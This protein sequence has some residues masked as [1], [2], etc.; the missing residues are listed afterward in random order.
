MKLIKLECPGCG[1]S[2]EVDMENMITFCPYCGNK[3]Y[4]DDESV[5]ININYRDEA[6]VIDAEIRKEEFDRWQ[7]I[8]DAE[9]Q[10]FEKD[11]SSWKKLLGVWK[12]W[13]TFGALG[14]F[15]LKMLSV[16]RDSISNEFSKTVFF[17]LMILSALLALIGGTMF[18]IVGPYLYFS[19]PKKKYDKLLDERAKRK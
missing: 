19:D 1:A 4:M 15:A 6:K 16:V 10:E 7:E 18:V 13:I 3:L 12:V 5:N 2:L 17:G 9:D 8:Y 11:Y 14:L